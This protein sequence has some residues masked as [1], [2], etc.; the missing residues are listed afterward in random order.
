MFNHLHYIN[1]SE[2]LGLSERERVG[3]SL[4][5]DLDLFWRGLI[6]AR[7]IQNWTENYLGRKYTVG[8]MHN[9][10]G[11]IKTGQK[12]TWEENTLWESCITLME[13]SCTCELD[14]LY[15]VK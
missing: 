2:K 1:N 5:S 4:G 14:V 13:I 6:K 7:Q 11:N 9:I 15:V 8:K 10:D 12:I 3:H